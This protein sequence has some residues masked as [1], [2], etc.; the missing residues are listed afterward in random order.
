MKILVID[1]DKM[2]CFAL[3]TIIE[4]ESDMEVVD[5]GHNYDDAINKYKEHKPDICLFDIRIGQKTGIDALRDIKIDYP[6]AKVIFLTT[7]LDQEYVKDSI[8][9]GSSGYILKDDFESI[10]PAIRAAL[11]GQNVFGNK[12]FDSLTLTPD[13]AQSEKGYIDNKDRKKGLIGILSEREIDV[14]ELI[15]D[16]LSNKEIASQ[17][18]LS[19]GTVRNYIS[20]ILVKLDLRDRTQLAI[21]Y[22]KS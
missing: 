8:K 12:V 1:D 2:I 20:S 16:G 14:L 21:Y 15:A 19:E 22:L 6:D 13:K 4:S 17:L 11:A 5:I 9:Y 18:H 3:K 7:F 10:C